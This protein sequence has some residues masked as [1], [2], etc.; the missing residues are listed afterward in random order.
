ML[1]NLIASL[2]H[3]RQCQMAPE[4]NQIVFM[5]QLVREILNASMEIGARK[6]AFAS[7]V[8][9]LIDYFKINQ[10]LRNL[11]SSVLCSFSEYELDEYTK[12]KSNS[13][14]IKLEEEYLGSTNIKGGLNFN[15][16]CIFD[17]LV[18]INKCISTFKFLVRR[19]KGMAKEI[20]DFYILKA[21]CLPD[22]NVTNCKNIQY[23]V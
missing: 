14:C 8:R 10:V 20:D 5:A 18:I 11:V 7:L 9:F 4:R 17:D 15:Q 2:E 16:Y 3:F 19:A 13:L 21:T 6:W 1:F 12:E 22:I 23:E